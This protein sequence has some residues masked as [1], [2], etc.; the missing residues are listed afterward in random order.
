M[1]A[2]LL[3]GKIVAS[4]IKEAIK[5][6]IK[7]IKAES[8][9]L[10]KLL[11]VQIG[12]DPGS[13]I[14][15]K[16]QA[17]LAEELGISYVLKNFDSNVTETALL[18]FISEEN[19]NPDINGII[20]QMPLPKHIDQKKIIYA[21]SPIKD[22]EGMH[23]EN[24]GKVLLGDTTLSCCTAKSCMELL[25]WTKENIYGKEAVVIGHSDIVG[26]PIT[27]MLLN[28]FATTTTCHIAT[29]QKGL[30]ESHVKRAEILIVAV[31]KAGVIKGEWIKDGAIVIDAGINRVDGKV[32][33]DVEFEQASKKAKFITP[34]PGGVGL[35][36][37]AVLMKNA[38]D[39]FKIQKGI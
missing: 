7:L 33:G 27:L 31:G 29:A 37:V 4:K 26:K 18:K 5:K 6:D 36:T 17:K 10:P 12:S 22:A 1:A 13:L 28:K 34:V 21:I 39:A 15:V 24:L 30:L 8:D 14:Y 9:K 20:L 16:S 23:P 25:D 11:S 35:V 38:V 2:V 19:I 32:V 3:E